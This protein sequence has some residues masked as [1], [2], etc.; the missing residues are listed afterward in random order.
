MAQES[1]GGKEI[2]LL[3]ERDISDAVMKRVRDLE[4]GKA[5]VLPPNYSPENALKGAYLII[6]QTV[7]KDKR[8]A[9]SVCT[10]ESIAESLLDMVKQGLNPTKSQCYFIVRGDKLTLMRSYFGTERALRT[11]MPEVYKVPCLTIHEGDEIEIEVVNDLSRPDMAGERI[12]KRHVQKFGATDRPITGAYGYIIGTDGK[13][14]ATD[15]MTVKEIHASWKKSNMQVFDK[16][17]NVLPSSTHG[18]FPV[19]MAKKTLLSRMCKRP[20]KTTDDKSLTEQQ[21]AFIRTTEN[22][23]NGSDIEGE[24]EV[25]DGKQKALGNAPTQK[26]PD[27]PTKPEAKEPQDQ[28][29]EPEKG[30]DIADM[31]A[32][33]D[34]QPF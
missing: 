8:P 22:E 34:G 2:A 1:L 13:L 30:D 11:V 9:L 7:D 5:L 20:F 3:K 32:Q 23:Y 26:Q 6:K 17:G 31:F 29:S 10:N 12:V 18:Q 15:I 21:Q 14:I 24:Y 4:T 33:G 27:P 28:K 16:D 25:P 19:E